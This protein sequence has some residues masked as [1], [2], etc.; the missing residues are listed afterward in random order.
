MLHR[1]ALVTFMLLL[2]IFSAQSAEN[3]ALGAGGAMQQAEQSTDQMRSYTSEV[4]K[5]VETLSTAPGFIEG[6]SKE[7]S[8]VMQGIDGRPTQALP[9][10]RSLP[11]LSPELLQRTRSDISK[12]F[13][14]AQG[15]KMPTAMEQKS[16]PQ[17]YLFVSFSMPSVT[18]K[19]LLRQA[20]RIEG[21]LIL[22]GLVD[23][24]LEK[25]KDKITELLEVDDLG[26]AQIKGGLAIDPTL[27]ERFDISQVP[28]FVL[29]HKPA[30]RCTE[31]GCPN[32]DYARLSGDST[33]EYVLET[34]AREAPMMKHSAQ[35]LLGK[36]KRG[37]E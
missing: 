9:N 37:F 25:T 28:S 31:A 17:F 1:Y 29:T 12:L 16:G 34:M 33:I 7:A 27:F 14:Q 8:N 15:Q 2:V 21:S 5:Q 3:S 32:I 10:L 36:M 13:D 23:D 6:L 19:R 11:E 26:H 18:L 35:V 22:R 4:L 30:E 20:S 24:D